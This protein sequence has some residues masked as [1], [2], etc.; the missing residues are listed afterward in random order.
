MK[1]YFTALSHPSQAVRGMLELKGLAYEIV[2]VIPS[3]Q[4]LHTRLA[5]FRGGTIPAL[6]VDGHRVQ[7]SR[8]IARVLDQLNPEP[9][10]LPSDPQLRARVEAAERWGEGELQSIAR[11]VVRFGFARR[12]EPRRWLAEQRSWPAPG[13]AA[14]MSAPAAFYS[15]HLSEP[16]G[17]RAD[18]AS[19]RADLEALPR[20]LDRADALLEEGTLA[21]DPPNAA[22]FQVLA[23]ISLLQAM[24]DLHEYIASRPC[25]VA[26]HELFPDYPTP[27]PPCLPDGW[28]RQ[29]AQTPAA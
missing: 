22:T 17:S 19:V 25:G 16:D 15:A 1:L 28:V 11:R 20:A 26:A 10:L 14:Y 21:T 2:D 27:I 3:N 12:A 8:Q 24:A 18:E 4:R 23:S 13:L 6:K 9:P 5:G 29:L 7:G